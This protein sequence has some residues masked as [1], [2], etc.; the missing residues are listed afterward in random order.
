M[1]DPPLELLAFPQ[2]VLFSQRPLA[3][4]VHQGAIGDCYFCCAL[5]LLAEF[6]PQLIKQM[7]HPTKQGTFEVTMHNEMAQKQ[8]AIE[9]SAE[10]FVEGPRQATGAAE[11]GLGPRRPLEGSAQEGVRGRRKEPR[12]VR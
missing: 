2:A 3:D 12:T 7:I 8:F 4:E 1:W 10:L 11:S 9:I 6:A 5:T